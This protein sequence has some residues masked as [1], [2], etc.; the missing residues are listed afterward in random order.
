[1][2]TKRTYIIKLYNY[3]H[4]PHNDNNMYIML[5]KRTTF[6]FLGFIPLYS[7]DDEIRTNIW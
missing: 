5:V 1:M 7:R 2:I 4:K 6:Y 3:S